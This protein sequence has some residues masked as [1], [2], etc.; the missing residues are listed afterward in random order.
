MF[1]MTFLT[2]LALIFMCLNHPISMGI[3][4]IIQTLLSAMMIGS[5]MNC[6]WFSYILV[7][8]MLSGML[9]L[10]IY[11]ASMASNEKFSLSMKLMLTVTL[12]LL[13]MLIIN[14]KSPESVIQ[15]N[16]NN[17]ILSLNK[18][19]NQKTL[20]VT[21]MMV[22]YLLFSMIVVSKIVNINEGPLRMKK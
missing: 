16:N 1:F 17:F 8:T 21:L 22:I 18:L 9:V 3:M 11:M 10:F 12:F 15:L 14:Y 6:F 5:M 13:M 7:I 2:T 19:F 4:I 20:M